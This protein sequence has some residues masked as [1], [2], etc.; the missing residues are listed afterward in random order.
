MG[1][2]AVH[3]ETANSLETSSFINALSRFLN[4]RSYV[5]QLRSNPGTNFVG[6]RNELMEALSEMNQDRVQEYLLQNRCEWIPSNF[7][8]GKG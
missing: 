6:A 8:S 3:L 1:S 7:L 5:R 2:R 4:R